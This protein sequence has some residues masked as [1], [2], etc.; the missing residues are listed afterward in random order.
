MLVIREAQM[1][2]FEQGVMRNFELR[3]LEHVKQFFPKQCAILGDEQARQ[4]IRL[5]IDRARTYGLVSER[6]IHLYV[7]LMFM[8]G[9]HFDRDP[10]LPWAARILTSEAISDPGL[11]ADRVYDTA[12]RYLNRVAGKNNEHLQRALL[13]AQ[14]LPAA[15]LARSREAKQQNQSFGEHMMK[16]LNALFPEKCDAVGERAVQQVVR[17]GYEKARRYN[18]ITEAGAAVYT[19]VMFLLGS[20]FDGD[21]QYPW[22]E[23]ILRD[24]ALDDPAQKGERLYQGAMTHLQKWLA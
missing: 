4:V 12:M 23:A 3:V 18:L 2:A 9:S 1:A 11:R 21:P 6:D 5:G 17:D 16:L 8:L 15:T 13:K 7:G 20:G 19:G 22:A 10:Q 14:E 24:A